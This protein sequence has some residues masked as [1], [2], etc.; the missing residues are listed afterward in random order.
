V[1]REPTARSAVG[2]HELLEKLTYLRVCEFL[3]PLMH[4]PQ[5]NGRISRNK[6]GR[7]SRS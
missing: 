1:V 5:L 6:A 7:K 4:L 2:Y 3:L